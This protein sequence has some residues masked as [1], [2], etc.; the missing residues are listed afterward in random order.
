MDYIYPAYAK[1]STGKATIKQDFTVNPD[2]AFKKSK[3]LDPLKSCISQPLRNANFIGPSRMR[4]A[5][6]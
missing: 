3:T 6:F 4:D 1:S 5:G 2:I